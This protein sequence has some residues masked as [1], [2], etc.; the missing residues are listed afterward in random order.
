MVLVCCALKSLD[1]TVNKNEVS[2]N[3]AVCRTS[4][5]TQVQYNT[6]KCTSYNHNNANKK[7]KCSLLC[8]SQSSFVLTGSISSMLSLF[9]LIIGALLYHSYL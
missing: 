5:T 9:Q 7:C 3:Q 1:F 4:S 2:S 8:D 6:K